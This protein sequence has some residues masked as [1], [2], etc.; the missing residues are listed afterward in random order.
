MQHPRFDE[1]SKEIRH[2]IVKC[3]QPNRKCCKDILEVGGRYFPTSEIRFKIQ[4]K[5]DCT[6]RN[7]IYTLICKK[8]EDTYIGETVNL[9]SRM[10][11][12]RNNSTKS[13]YA[14]MVASR[15]L[16]EWY[17]CPIYKMKEE[18]KIAR[19]VREDYIKL[20]KPNLNADSRNLLHLGL[21]S[22]DIAG[23]SS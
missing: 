18:N 17:V 23:K 10:N 9:R 7:V 13:D 22:P 2:R 3:G 4:A 14:V 11:T 15:H 16:Y 19:L 20:L 6:V 12:H 1:F 5:M 21:A 8:C